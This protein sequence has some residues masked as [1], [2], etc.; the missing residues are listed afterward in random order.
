MKKN[1]YILKTYNCVGEVLF[2]KVF[3]TN[4]QAEKYV[5]ENGIHYDE[6]AWDITKK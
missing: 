4:Y 3:P 1:K 2:K 5:I 6:P